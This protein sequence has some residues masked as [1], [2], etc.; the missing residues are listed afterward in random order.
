MVKKQQ[1]QYGKAP[2]G[3]P[4]RS[5][6]GHALQTVLVMLCDVRWPR[7]FSSLLRLSLRVTLPQ[8]P[9]RGPPRLPSPQLSVPSL[10]G[11]SHPPLIDPNTRGRLTLPKSIPLG[12]T[13]P[14]NI[15]TKP[16]AA[17]LTSSH[18]PVGL[19]Y[20]APLKAHPSPASAPIA[21]QRDTA[22]PRTRASPLSQTH[23]ADS[24]F[25]TRSRLH[26]P[27]PSGPFPDRCQS[28]QFRI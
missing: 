26:V 3:R 24:S 2:L 12:R 25:P 20:L 9:V 19:L 23:P 7:G 1:Q 16:P 28:V 22:E 11:L 8:G 10:P 18:A 13:S 15:Q 27:P 21:P 17:S 4:V 6:D 14:L 5:A